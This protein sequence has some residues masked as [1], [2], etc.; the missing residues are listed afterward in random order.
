MMRRGGVL[1]FTM[2]AVSA[3]AQPAEA[4]P[5][6]PPFIQQYWDLNYSPP[7]T[8]CHVSPTGGLGTANTPFAVYMRSRGLRAYDLASLQ[9]ALD[10]NRAEMQDSDNDGDTDYAEI[11][12]GHDPNGSAIGPT[13]N[14]GFACSFAKPERAPSASGWCAPVALLLPLLLLFTRRYLRSR[15]R[16]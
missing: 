10:A 16:R 3:V 13:P 9:T 12:G 15:Q 14:F 4:T 7:C 6:F 1:A 11:V 5:N 2:A 8:I